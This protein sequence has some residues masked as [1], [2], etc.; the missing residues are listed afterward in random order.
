M[1]RDQHEAVRAVFDQG[2]GHPASRIELQP[3]RPATAFV[4]NQ[5]RTTITVEAFAVVD[6]YADEKEDPWNSPQA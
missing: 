1:S 2:W 6:F 3:M 4:S 5:D